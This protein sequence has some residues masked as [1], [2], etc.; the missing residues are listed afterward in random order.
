MNN[1]IDLK[2][3]HKQ[4]NRKPFN[5]DILIILLLSFF[6]GLADGF[7]YIYRDETFCFIQTGNLVKAIIAYVDNQSI[8]GTYILIVFLAFALGCYIYWFVL[9]ALKKS[10]LN[11]KIFSLII[12]MILLIPSII[13][14][15]NSQ[16]YLA[17]D[18]LIS[19]IPLSFV[20]SVI[21]V[22]FSRILIGKN[23]SFVFNSAI[24]TGNSKAMM[25]S[26]ATYSKTKNKVKGLEALVY[27]IIIIAFVIGIIVSG[28]ISIYINY[29]SWD[30]YINLIL[31][32][33]ILLVT[34]TVLTIQHYKNKNISQQ[35]NQQEI[36]N[37]IIVQ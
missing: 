22:A 36:E 8:N 5:L 25:V 16:N 14:K 23:S 31:L 6:G 21:A 1:K 15:F 34:I 27:L 10:K 3:K 18:N 24:M 29:D 7:S 19:G 28:I 13:F 9:D 12:V 37:R 26:A 17:A 30:F 35:K 33:F 11:Y 20:G 32:Y 4:T 2:S